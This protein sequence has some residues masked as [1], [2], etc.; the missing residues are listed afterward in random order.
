MACLRQ[1]F[2]L[3][4]LLGSIGRMWPRAQAAWYDPEDLVIIVPVFQETGIIEDTCNFFAQLIAPHVSCR[5]LICGTARERID[6]VNPTLLLARRA[7][8]GMARCDVIEAPNSAADKAG[9]LEFA[10]RRSGS[11]PTTYLCLYDVDSRPERATLSE[12]EQLRRSAAPSIIQQH[13]LFVGNLDAIRSRPLQLGQ[14]LYQ[15][16]W[17]LAHEIPRY[18]LY[19]A[20]ITP[21]AHLVGH[22]LFLRKSVIDDFRGMPTGAIVDD[23]H[24]GFFATAQKLSIESMKSVDIADNPTT[25]SETFRQLYGWSRGP[26]DV[27]EYVKNFRHTGNTLSQIKS[28]A[29]CVVAYMYWL[30]WILTTPVMILLTSMLIM[31][32]LTALIW[33]CLYLVDFIICYFAMSRVFKIRGLPGLLSSLCAMYAFALVCSVP[34]FVAF[35]DKIRGVRGQKYKTTHQGP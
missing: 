25:L 4:G 35:F 26:L 9:Q 29:T 1:A 10:V 32:N 12:F 7:L 3:C 17:T 6:G 8:Q 31:G 27:R 14:A 30:Q 15:S 28:A 20:G 13:S 21:Y 19:R 18:A 2:N 24:L 22:G 16:R 23:A 34:A 11:R 5:L 33:A